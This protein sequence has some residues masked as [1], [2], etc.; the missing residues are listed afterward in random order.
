MGREPFRSL[1]SLLEGEALNASFV[2]LDKSTGQARRLTIEDSYAFASEC[3]LNAGVPD[4]VANHFLTARYAHVFSWFVYRFHPLAQTQALLSLEFGLR[5]RFATIATSVRPTGR[6]PM[7][8]DLLHRGVDAGLIRDRGFRIWPGRRMNEA[9]DG[10]DWVEGHLIPLLLAFR[11]DYAHGA[12]TLMPDGLFLVTV[13]D[14]LNQV[15]P[16]HS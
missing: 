12:A 1:D 8:R 16:A 10:V 11:N 14:W 4:D 2:R 7:L 15:F 3:E 9:G 5:L 13:A 6:P